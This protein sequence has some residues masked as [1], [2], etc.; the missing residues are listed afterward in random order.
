MKQQTISLTI[1]I[2]EPCKENWHDMNQLEQGVYCKS[3]C[4]EVMDFSTLTDSEIIKYIEKRKDEKM[5]G[6]F[7]KEQ[8]NKPLIHISPDILHMN[9]PLWKK[10][11][12]A[13]LICFSSF[14][15]S[16]ESKSSSYEDIQVPKQPVV[17]ATLLS[18]PAKK[19]NSYI[20]LSEKDSVDASCIVTFGYIT[21]TSE[22]KIKAP[23]II[24][25]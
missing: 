15:I 23:T 8:L 12:A 21:V 25:P 11:L 5:C 9:I 10:F 17:T 3:C 14:L 24:T 19:A 18:T 4:K 13:V 20:N 6:R 16:C 2:A 22:T 7:K 1:N